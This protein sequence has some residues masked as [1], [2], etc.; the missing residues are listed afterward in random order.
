MFGVGHSG[1]EWRKKKQGHDFA[2]LVLLSNADL[3]A[4][5]VS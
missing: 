1:S 2:I 4:A 3:S 5:Q